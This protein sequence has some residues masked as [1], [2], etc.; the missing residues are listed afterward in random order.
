MSALF[1]LK[2]PYQ[3]S[4]DPLIGRCITCLPCLQRL[5]SSPYLSVPYI[6][7]MHVL[8]LYLSRIQLS[9]R[10]QRAVLLQPALSSNPTLQA[11]SPQHIHLKIHSVLPPPPLPARLCQT[12]GGLFP[13]KIHLFEE[14]PG[15][16]LRRLGP[17]CLKPKAQKHPSSSGVPTSNKAFFPHTPQSSSA[18]CPLCDPRASTG[19]APCLAGIVTKMTSP[20]GQGQGQTQG[21]SK[22]QDQGESE[23]HRAS[24]AAEAHR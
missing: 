17:G 9:I 14:K 21:H 22:G 19:L 3:F 4:V 7:S 10:Q 20:Q 13:S 12:T 11:D 23:S 18:P 15:F 1:L 8:D 16:S 2:T 24:A 6:C 5:C